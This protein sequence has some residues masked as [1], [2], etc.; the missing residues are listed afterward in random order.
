MKKLGFAFSAPLPPLPLFSK[1][2]FSPIVREGRLNSADEM[3][4]T[5]QKDAID[6]HW[7]AQLEAIGSDFPYDEVFV[8]NRSRLVETV[9]V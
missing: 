8:T 7:R 3:V 6:D 9:S 5:M 4:T 1:E 2:A